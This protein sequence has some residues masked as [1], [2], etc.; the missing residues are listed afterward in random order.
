MK[1][2][3][4]ASIAVATGLGWLLGA[5]APA[6]ADACP[7]AGAPWLRVAF[8]G[9]AL[10]AALRGR[11]LVQLAADLQGHGLAPCPADAVD[12]TA[13]PPLADV[14]LALSPGAV[15]SLE[16]R[17]AVTDKRMGR[18]LP[19]ASVPRDAL[20]LSIALAAEE[21]LRASWIE[22]EFAP[23][24]ANAT[25]TTT[26]TT[27]SSTTAT[28]LRPGTPSASAP[29]V[30]QVVH[31]VNAEQVA[32]MPM[33]TQLAQAARTS[34]TTA[35][36]KSDET[37]SNGAGPSHSAWFAQASLVGA[38]DRSAGGQTDLG[39]DVRFSAGG[40]LAANARVGYR[41][42]PNVTST[43]GDVQ[44]REV[45]AGLGLA[46]ALVRRDAPWGV[47]LGARADVIDVQFSGVAASGAQATSGSAFGATLGGVVGG[48][49]RLAGP[50]RVVAE[51]ALGAPLRAVAA[52]DEGV[53]ATGV[54]GL[55]FGAAL[56]V[57]ATLG[58][59]TP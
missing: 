49:F 44:G 50:W 36:T 9:D 26:G 17:D 14:T 1:R 54:S 47:D 59:A 57:A 12:G 51:A 31:D 37:D 45:V 8:A 19:L 38:I 7:P 11:V 10:D 21:L 48:W 24:P 29:P 58:D 28:A 33:V 43:H 15:L 18:E 42:A 39:G 22:A 53:A 27:A 2:A 20:A 40:R 23:Q 32:R 25:T 30:P 16:V 4:I 6:R 3:A 5:S 55:T 46:Y 35:S 13:A 34:S 56:G 41:A 52:T